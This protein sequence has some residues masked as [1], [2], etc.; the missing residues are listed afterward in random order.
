VRRAKYD[1]C[2][3]LRGTRAQDAMRRYIELAATLPG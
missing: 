2:S 1:A 3:A